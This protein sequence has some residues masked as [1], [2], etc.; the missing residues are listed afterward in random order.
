MAEASLILPSN[1][2]NSIEATNTYAVIKKG[3]QTV[4]SKAAV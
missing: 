3:L 1:E 2:Q 4:P